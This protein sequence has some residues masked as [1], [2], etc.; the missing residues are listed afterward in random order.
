MRL[1]GR[2]PEEFS[3]LPLLSLA[4]ML[5]CSPTISTAQDTGGQGAGA[6]TKDDTQQA[7][8]DEAKED[9]SKEDS[10][11][12]EKESKPPR[13]IEISDAKDWQSVRGFSRSRDAKWCAFNVRPSEGDV[14]ITIRTIDGETVHTFEGGPSTGSP[15]FSY[16][17]RWVAFV[18]RAKEKE[19]EAATKAKKPVP[20]K[21]I[22]IDLESGEKTEFEESTSFSFG[23]EASVWM[24]IRKQ[25]ASSSGGG[26]QDWSGS[27]LVLHHLHENVQ[28][29]LGNVSD[30]EFNKTGSLLA[31]LIDAQGMLGNGLHLFHPDNKQIQVLESSKHRY[32][33]LNWS[34][35]GDALACLKEVDSDKHENKLHELIGYRN[36]GG[37]SSERFH[38]DVAK[39]PGV[40]EHLTISPNR[41]PSW[42]ENRDGVLF[43]V[44]DSKPKPEEE[45]KAEGKNGSDKEADL[46]IWH[47]QDRRMQSQQQVQESSDKRMNYLCVFRIDDQKSIQLGN[48]SMPRVSTSRPH[49]YAI[50][51]DNAAYELSGNL[52]GQRYSDVYVI[53]MQTGKRTLA[54]EKNRWSFGVS[55]TGDRML[56]YV[57]GHY[58]AYDLA[59][60][61]TRN[62]TEGVPTSFIDTEDDHPV[63]DPPVRPA[64]WTQDGTAVLLSD[65][66]DIWRVPLA[67]G[68]A[69]NL[70]VN[71]KADGIRYSSMFQFDPEKPGVDF[72][73]S[74][75]LAAYGEWT[76]K[77]G[78][79][80][81]AE[82]TTGVEMLL[83]EDASIRFAGKLEDSEHFTFTKQTSQ[84][85]LNFYVAGPDL[86]D[87]VQLTDIN[88][89]QKN[90]LWSSGVR[91]VDYESTNGVKLQA[92]LHLPANYIEGKSYPTVVYIYEKLSQGA[93][94]Y[95]T[96]RVG[97]FSPSIYTSQGYAV[98]TPDI[99]YR[100]N[101][102]GLS[103]VECVLPA[104]DAAIATGIVDG[105]HV[106]L[107]GHSWGGYQTSFLITQTDRF[108]AAVAGAPLTN[109]ISMYSSIY[110]NSGSANQPIFESS[111]GRFTGGYWTNLRAY[112]RNSPVY[113]ARRVKTPLLLL[114]NDKDG[115]VDWNQGIEYFNTLRRLGKPV[116]MLQYKGENHGL[117]DLANRKDYSYRMLDFFN[118]YLKGEEAADWWKEGVDHLDLKD[119]IRDYRSGNEPAEK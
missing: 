1:M 106:G 69:T 112:A 64:G 51:N 22:L 107:H 60:G 16:D 4:L 108:K 119:H 24:A 79:G 46:V 88:P 19:A 105:E 114:H 14:E 35:E 6:A 81:I 20:S 101:D 7:Q 87:A 57:D 12:E 78:I 75:Y 34:R 77:S 93:N 29:N 117:A 95:S 91:L 3:M 49:R 116:V 40:E 97:G 33:Q 67:G 44:H 94:N 110:W 21:V 80:R 2:I 47:W 28:L 62:L 38:L 104:L 89:Q 76:K 59:T 71:G 10:A 42:T 103:S 61:Q 111:Q 8:E 65:N 54:L 26:S 48:E 53:D 50:A 63:T 18:S 99:V 5:I 32:K 70:T 72:S 82:G 55:P 23:G 9:E 68:E 118:Q 92:A 45:D 66:W 52:D 58:H 30:F 27:D 15:T 36:V 109:L 100:V 25:R 39:D 115:A 74:V 83:W 41:A 11:D 113:H 96:P 90:F 13:Q 73:R 86:K 84:H 56:Y 85:P 37:A 17:S 102:P 31:M 98:L 43:G